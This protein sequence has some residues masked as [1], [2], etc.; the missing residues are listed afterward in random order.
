MRG[1]IG[2]I[3]Y[4]KPLPGTKERSWFWLTQL[5]AACALCEFVCEHNDHSLSP[6]RRK[7]LEKVTRRIRWYYSRHYIDKDFDL[8]LEPYPAADTETSLAIL[9][10]AY[11]V[12]QISHLG[13]HA[14]KPK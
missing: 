12:L 9:K 11:Q 8:G 14:I 13:R 4:V 1:P 6:D 10:L 7:W 2:S 3:W 5:A